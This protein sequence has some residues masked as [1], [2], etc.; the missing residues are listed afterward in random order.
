MVVA[1]GV[2]AGAARAQYGADGGQW[3]NYSGDKG[4]TKYA[5]LDQIDL[6]NV[7]DLRIAW[8]RP[9]VSDEV[10][11]ANPDLRGGNNYENTPLMAGGSLFISTGVGMIAAL[12]AA[13]G[14]T[15]WIYNPSGDGLAVQGR[16]GRASRGVAY[17]S[18]GEEKRVLAV[19][20]EY[21]IALDPDTGRLLAGFGEGGKV[22]LKQGLSRPVTRFR[23]SSAPTVCRDVV[24]VGSAI[25]DIGS[26]VGSPRKEMPPGDVRGY[27]VRTGRLLWLF[28]TIPQQG[29]FGNESWED[30]SWEYTGNTNVW[31]SMS[32]DE[33]LGYV[34]LPLTTPTND[35]Y[36]G[37]RLGD[38]LFAETLVC[39]DVETGRRVWHFQTTHH[40][41][42]DYD[43]P[44]AP[45]LC[46]ITVDGREIKAVA[47]V[48]KQAFC[49]VF[50]RVTGEPVWPIEEREVPQS[51]AP[52]ERTSPTQPFPTRPP[53]FDQQGVTLDD[54]IDFTPQL[55]AEAI[56]II[57][58]FQ[59]GPIFTP[60]MLPIDGADE[61]K[62]TIQMPGSVGGANWNGAAFDPETG[63]L[64]V[65]SVHSPIVIVLAKPDPDKSN[66][67]YVRRG[68][69]FLDGPQG[70]PIFKPPYG[71]ITAIDLNRGEEVW[72]APNGDGPRDHPLLKELNLAPLGQPGRAAPLL[73]KT[74]LFIGE[75][76]P[77]GI[78]IPPGGG[79]NMFRAYDK[80]SGA[81]VWEIEL[82]AGTT[83][84]P[85]TYMTGG[86]QYVVVAVGARNHPAEMIALSLP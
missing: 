22:D 61:K 7:K 33:E 68:F 65:P 23:W 6:A 59:Y 51:T 16:G 9:A 78:R 37:H 42:W 2:G 26:T 62:G 71:R 79:G 57:E 34:Y 56:E 41:L 53:P 77:G 75:G 80:A 20:G 3:A 86:K 54:L 29:E 67:D 35:W 58:Q 46:D 64:Y 45:I 52:G 25:S 15:R 63:I 83:G 49:F 40:G 31:S 18:G 85:M 69:L 8:R 55:R 12:D 48:T 72:M 70:L 36:G 24:V 32:A 82:P 47:Q 43:L 73:T 44:A 1:I 81:V 14:K 10:R 11:E 39:L 76:S 5:A 28:Q 17:W 13:S 50:D 21:L 19:T 38:N 60:P 74:L 84:A 30:G 4:S 66:L 27:D